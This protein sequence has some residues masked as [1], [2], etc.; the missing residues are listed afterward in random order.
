MRFTYRP[1]PT[2]RPAPTL[3]GLS[4]RY[5]PVL[6]VTATTPA[7]SW[8]HP[9]LVD[10]GAD[11]SIFPETTARRLGIDLTT[12]PQGDSVV[13]GGQVFSCRYALVRLSISDGIERYEWETL[14]G[15]LPAPMRWP[16]LGLTGFFQFFEV[17]LS[18]E[19]QEVT[20]VPSAAFPGVIAR[21]PSAGP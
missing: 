7:G 8:V 15:F 10:S 16:L 12:A 11:D 4:I 2:R 20:I 18:G 21:P 3:G 13:V 5:K 19:R 1:Y 17:T 9:C 6:T 14:V